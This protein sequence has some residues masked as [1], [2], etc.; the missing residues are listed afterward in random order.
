MS[1]SGAGSAHQDSVFAC[2]GYVV[3]STTSITGGSA[4]AFLSSHHVV[5]GS[6]FGAVT[7]IDF[8]EVDV[9]IL[10]QWGDVEGLC[11]ELDHFAGE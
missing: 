2:G 11:D 1:S 10:N 7:S 4:G 5:V 6:T 8:K 3:S 9:S